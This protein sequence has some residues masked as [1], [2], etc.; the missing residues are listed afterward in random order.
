MNAQSTEIVNTK[1]Y[2]SF[3][4]DIKNDIQT[5][6]VRA[7]LAVNKELILLYFRVGS[8]ILKRQKSLGWGSKVIKQL[9]QD[10]KMEFPNITGFS[11][12][13]LWYMRQFAAEYTAEIFLQHPIG[14]IPWGH[15][16]DLMTKIKDHQTR[17]WYIRKT[18]ENGWSRNILAMHIDA[19]SH[20]KLGAAQTNFAATLPKLNS[21]LVQSLI[22]S[23]YNFEFLGLAGDV[24]EKVIEKG[25]IDN[26]RRFLLELGTGFSFLGSQ[27]RVTLAG[28]E[29][30]IDMLM[31]HVKL[32][33]YIVLELKAGKF[34]PEYAGKLS[35]YLTA[36]DK[37]VKDEND[38]PTI[39]ILLCQS[40]NKLM[41]DYCLGD[42]RKPIGV[43]EYKAGTLP[44]DV[45]K[46]LPSQ[47]QFQH[48][49]KIMDTKEVNTKPE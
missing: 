23:E 17:L 11:K 31:Y 7:H 2:I 39:G 4:N 42:I 16:I 46:Y 48:L 18:I 5:S 21:D 33:S 45:R 13:N 47:E 34:K 24:H 3:L 22:K 26:I 29:F 12:Q 15:N 43:S 32:K 27:Y 20:L 10:L 44:E 19:E 49:M 36:I 41:V 40:A 8:G 28:E 14:E 38:N 37:E 1:D 6:R 35:F 30:V 25:L 9:S